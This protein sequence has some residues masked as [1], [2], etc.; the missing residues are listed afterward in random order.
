M[1][2]EIDPQQQ[3]QDDA[4]QVLN[5][6]GIENVGHFVTDAQALA[7]A[8]TV[9]VQE[10][11]AGYKT[12]EFWLT[13]A[14]VIATAVGAVPTPHDAKGY[15]LVVLVAVYALARGLAK[16]GVGNV[17]ETPVDGE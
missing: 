4:T 14:G 5:H 1:N 17:V 15:V 8:V 7:P 6:P 12:T 2:P 9:A 13:V 16:K 10:T 11:K 3:F